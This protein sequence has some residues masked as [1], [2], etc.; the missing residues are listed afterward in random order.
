METVKVNFLN[1]NGLKLTGYLDFPNDKNPRAYAVFAHCFT[2]SKDLK[3]I[4]N[5]N[6]SL[7]NSGIAS[8]RFDFTGIGESEGDFS[9]SNYTGYIEDILSSVDFLNKNYESPE[10][11][12]GHSLGGC[13]AIESASEIPSIKAVAVIGSPAEPSNLSEKLKRTK[14]IAAREGEA[15]AEIGGV[16]YLFKKQFFIDIEKHKLEPFIRNLQKPLLI[17]HSPS[18]IY[19]NIENAELIFQAAKYPKSFIS[20]DGIDHLM[21]KKQDAMYVGG[22]I[23]VWAQKYL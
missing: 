22:L 19:T 7:T 4:A 14:E 1:K 6:E 12:I 16:K 2:C 10:L 9:N 15:Q 18:D 11:M 17:M 3:A 23:A 21:L 20:L 13:T 8:L 5:I